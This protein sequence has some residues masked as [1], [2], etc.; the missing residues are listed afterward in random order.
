MHAMAI[1]SWASLC[2]PLKPLT[3]VLDSFRPKIGTASRVRN[4]SN[5]GP[6][7]ISLRRPEP[8]GARDGAQEHSTSSHGSQ[9]Q[10]Q[11][12]RCHGT[13]V[14]P[15]HVSNHQQ[16]NQGAGADG[17][18]TS[19]ADKHQKAGLNDKVAQARTSQPAKRKATDRKAQK[20]RC[21]DE[22]EI[23]AHPPVQPKPELE[24]QQHE[25]AADDDRKS[26][27][28]RRRRRKLDFVAF[29]CDDDKPPEK[30]VARGAKGK[31]R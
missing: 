24:D 5:N 30:L 15:L 13:M 27:N 25:V 10:E 19:G 29:Y 9:Q 18:P 4:R 20:K 28:D 31:G 11:M 8:P 2:G 3:L 12:M 14:A 22:N 23:L 21:S 1:P 7:S 6:A 26:K 16:G 17:P